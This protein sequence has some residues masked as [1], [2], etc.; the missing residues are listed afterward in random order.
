[1]MNEQ[2][3]QQ[4]VENASRLRDEFLATVAEEMRAPLN[5]ILSWVILLRKHPLNQ[6]ETERVLEAMERSTKELLAVASSLGNN[7]DNRDNDLIQASLPSLP[8][9]ELSTHNGQGM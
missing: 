2:E 5:A 9:G 4:R 8:A 1:M 6:E 3:A 7:L